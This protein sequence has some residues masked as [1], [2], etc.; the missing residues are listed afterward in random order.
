[1]GADIGVG[2]TPEGN[3]VDAHGRV[4]VTDYEFGRLQVFDTD[5]NWLESWGA[6]SLANSLF[7]RPVA[8][9]F[10]EHGRFYVVNQGTGHLQIFALPGS[11]RSG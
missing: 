3:A 4:V 6:E 2:G 8:I 10:D 5:G 7:H 11:E 1:M 9:A